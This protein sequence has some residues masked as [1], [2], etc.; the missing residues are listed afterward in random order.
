MRQANC[1]VFASCDSHHS[2]TSPTISEGREGGYTALLF[3]FELQVGISE[4]TRP[5][6]IAG[7]LVPTNSLEAVELDG[8]SGWRIGD[9]LV[10]D[11]PDGEYD[12]E[13]LADVMLRLTGAK[14][15]ELLVDA[16]GKTTG[17]VVGVCLS[18]ADASQGANYV[19]AGKGWAGD[20][21]A[22]M[23]EIHEWE[24]ALAGI[25]CEAGVFAVLAVNE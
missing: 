3:H 13:T 10:L 9:I 4:R 23:V 6:A 12:N 24:L 15:A 11:D 1:S 17:C 19:T 22:V 8:R 14:D 7:C 20:L 2:S 18:T 25:K 21:A 16:D 5:Y